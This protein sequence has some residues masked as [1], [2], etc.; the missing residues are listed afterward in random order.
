MSADTAL[1]YASRAT[2]IVCLLLLTAVMV[3][4][5]MVNRQGRLPGLPRFAVTGLHRNLSLLAVGFL[6]VHV[7]TAIAGPV[8]HDRAGAATVIPLASPY[9]PLWTGLG[10]VSLDLMVALML[11]SLARARIGRRALAGR[12]LAGLRG[13]A[14]V[15]GAQPRAAAV[16]CGPG[17]LLWL[18]AACAA[19]VAAALAVRALAGATR[20]RPPAGRRGTG[21]P[22]AAARQQ[23][24]AAHRRRPPVRRTCS[25]AAR[26]SLAARTRRWPATTR[27]WLPGLVWPRGGRPMTVTSPAGPVPSGLRPGRQ[28]RRSPGCCLPAA[29]RT[30]CAPTWPLHGPLPTAAG[31][32][33]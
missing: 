14:A 12:A 18:S 5:I 7:V 24:A 4:G 19:A 33:G 26:P 31:P 21:P 3:L 29:A 17:P 8:R 10:A 2:G 15:P 27:R 23:A 6:A 22:E 32:G 28:G 30:G 9:R 11:T 13:L 20:C 1:W 16:T 25:L